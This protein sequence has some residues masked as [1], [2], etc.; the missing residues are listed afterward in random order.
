MTSSQGAYG[1]M[2]AMLP[3]GFALAGRFGWMTLDMDSSTSKLWEAGGGIHYYLQGFNAN[4]KL[5][6]LFYQPNAPELKRT[7]EVIFAMQA[8]F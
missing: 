8:K 6:Y 5:D 1:Q 4:F 3:F 2:Q 7:H